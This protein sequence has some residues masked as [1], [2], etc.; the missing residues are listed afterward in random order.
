MFISKKLTR[1]HNKLTNKFVYQ[2]QLLEFADNQVEENP[3]PV[4]VDRYEN[5]VDDYYEAKQE[6]NVFENRMN[7]IAKLQNLNALKQ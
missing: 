6:L 1:Q 5:I 2:A 7:R 4:G 3:D